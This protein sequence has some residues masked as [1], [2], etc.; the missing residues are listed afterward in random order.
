[1]RAVQRKWSV[2]ALA[3]GCTLALAI[4]SKAQGEAEPARLPPAAIAPV[5][6][7]VAP[8]VLIGDSSLQG[9]LDLGKM[10][11]DGD[12]YKTK[13]RD[14]SEATLTLRPDLQAA[15]ESVLEKAR[16]PLGAIVVTTIDGRVLA[17]AGRRFEDAKSAPDFALPA[18]VWAPAASIFKIVTSAALLSKGVKK[19]SKVCFH[20]GLRSVE[21]SHLVDNPKRDSTCE[22]LSFGLA[23]SQNA[24]I[25]KLASKHLNQKSLRAFA[26]RFGFDKD[27][28]FAVA[29]DQNHC[30]IPAEPL[31]LARTSAGFWNSELSPLGGALLANTVA[32]G[33]LKV[34]PRIV[35]Q[36]HRA[37]GSEVPVV[38][39]APE[40][41]IDEKVARDLAAMMEQTVS[42]GT[43]RKGFHDGRGRPFLGDVKVAGK[44]GSLSRNEPTY[45]GY[46]WFVGFAPADDPEIVIS[47]LL[48]NPMQWHLKAHTAARLVLEKAFPARH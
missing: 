5:T 12:V 23:K 36:L 48:G 40:R 46:S 39:P 19:D 45:L 9:K 24:I 8:A 29:T 42:T 16:A 13:L 43:A 33:G 3:S 22:S 32:S 37:D 17:Y 34:E 26:Q 11:L 30:S 10:R 7:P 18:K 14:G 2:W 41:V 47:V 4:A 15:A 38:G 28:R 1:M 31:E 27:I 6:A 44:T 21:P 35:A 25:A 20:G